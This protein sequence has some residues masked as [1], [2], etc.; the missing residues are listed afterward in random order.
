MTENISGAGNI[1]SAETFGAPTIGETMSAT[2]IE[3]VS[4]TDSFEVQFPNF[5]GVKDFIKDASRLRDI[6]KLSTRER[7]SEAE[8]AEV[9]ELRRRLKRADS[10]STLLFILR[11]RERGGYSFF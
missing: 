7:L 8:R 4:H 3:Q 11:S 6:Y 1:E 10:D 2:G 9:P 5:Y